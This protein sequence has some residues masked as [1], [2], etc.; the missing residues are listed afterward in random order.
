MEDNKHKVL[1]TVIGVGTLLVALAGATFAYFSATFTTTT[2][3]I[4]TSSMD[5]SVT[6]DTNTTHV[7]NIKPTTW[8][9]D[10]TKN[11][12]NEDIA[13]VSFKVKS[14]SSTAGTYSID[15]TT[16]G[17]ALNSGTVVEEEGKDAV[18][19]TGGSLDQVMYKLYK[20]SGSTYTPVS[21]A[22]GNL[23][24][25]ADAGDGNYATT[26]TPITIVN[27][28]PVSNNLNDQYV[29]FIYIENDEDGAQNKLQGL[30]FSVDVTGSA[31]QA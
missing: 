27:N 10:I 25:L 2:Q 23:S 21:G 12:A 16:P 5:L 30:D 22:E 26:V 13:K 3:E 4:T 29:I 28:A 6:A 20:V 1:L 7:T 19:L 31:A 8:D 14:S 18:A 15:M 24:S 9:S 11:V 17:L